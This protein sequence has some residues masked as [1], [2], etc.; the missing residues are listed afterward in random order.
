MDI[1]KYFI[2]SN[3]IK[4]TINELTDAAA[5]VSASGKEIRE[6]AECIIS[7]CQI[8]GTKA[9]AYKDMLFAKVE[10]L[11]RIAALYESA[12]VRFMSGA[13][14]LADGIPEEDVMPA[15]TTYSTFFNDQV[16]SEEVESNNILNI[17]RSK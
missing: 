6:A 7:S 15:L 12:S 17:I 2:K 5:T 8:P 4:D 1:K 9:E 10:D 11:Q 14:K 13:E 16:Q 3:K